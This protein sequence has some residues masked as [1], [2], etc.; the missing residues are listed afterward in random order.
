[1]SF[2][3]HSRIVLLMQNS[4]HSGHT[5]TRFAMPLPLATELRDHYPGDFRRIAVVTH[6]DDHIL[7]P[8]GGQPITSM[9]V[10]AQPA[11]PD[12]F[13]LKVIKGSRYLDD[14][15][16][17]LI[18]QA[19][20]KTL[21][22]NGEA[23]NHIVKID[24]KSSLRV[25]GI[26]EDIPE[27]TD[28]KGMNYIMNWK[29]LEAEQA[30]VREAATEWNDNNFT[31]LAELNPGADVALLNKKIRGML[32]GHARN[33][34]PEVGLHPMDRWHLYGEFKDGINTGG[35]IRYIWM[36]GSIG[37][38]VLLLA[39][40]NFMNLS[41]ARSEKRA[42]EVGIRKSIGSLRGQLIVQF[43]GESVLLAILAAVLGLL[44]AKASLP[45]FSQ[46]AGSEIDLPLSGRFI[47]AFAGLTLVV[48]L[49]AGSYPALYLSSF[50]AVK[51]LKGTFRVGP[52]AAIPRKVLI[53]LQFTVSI[54]LIIGT[55]VIFSQIIYVKNR[56]IGYDREG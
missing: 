21:F 15:S 29:Y 22:A 31:I 49:L 4:T 8:E 23:L 32:N 11:L 43:L 42:R 27:N 25:T 17:M 54:S 14:P 20:A 7:E 24:N 51:V 36:F 30:W 40:I 9:G 47:M 2:S 19:L 48:G 37:I 39:C 12:I 16:S 10:Y 28:W 50:N 44:L 18:S 41:T 35:S 56:P 38:F 55:M 3:N 33:D 34:K 52:A 1:S 26:Y 46:L 53:V 6:G 13:S 45:L 5:D